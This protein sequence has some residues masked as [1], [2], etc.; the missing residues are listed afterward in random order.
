MMYERKYTKLFVEYLHKKS[1]KLNELCISVS[2]DNLLDM[3]ELFAMFNKGYI[4]GD[5]YTSKLFGRR[6]RIDY[7]TKVLEDECTYDF[8]LIEVKTIKKG[9]FK[10]VKIFSLKDVKV[11]DKST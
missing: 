7:V 1:T 2:N 10:K 4:I 5:R 3:E 11:F 9:L 6:R 8:S